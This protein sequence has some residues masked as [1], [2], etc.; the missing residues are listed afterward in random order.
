MMG[1]VNYTPDLDLYDYEAVNAAFQGAV[2]TGDAHEAWNILLS[3]KE[4]AYWLG[5]EDYR[6]W[7]HLFEEAMPSIYG[8][9]NELEQQVDDI[10]YPPYQDEGDTRC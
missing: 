8:S 9:V 4:A 2:A 6:Q 3:V 10:L 7:P 1:P 5:I